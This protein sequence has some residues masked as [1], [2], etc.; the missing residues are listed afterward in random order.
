MKWVYFWNEAGREAVLPG[1]SPP[2]L[3]NATAADGADAAHAAPAAPARP[4]VSEAH[5][6]EPAV[7]P[8]ASA[9]E[10]VAAPAAPGALLPGPLSPGARQDDAEAHAAEP[11]AVVAALGASR[12]QE[13]AATELLGIPCKAPP[14]RL[15]SMELQ[16][17][18]IKAPPPYPPRT[19]IKASGSLPPGGLQLALLEPV[20]ALAA[21]G[22]LQ[23]WLIKAPPPRLID[24]HL[25]LLSLVEPAAAPAA[26]GAFQPGPLSPFQR[27][28]DSSRSL[29]R[30]GPVSWNEANWRRMVNEFFLREINANR[31][32]WFNL[33]RVSAF[34]R[35]F[36]HR[37]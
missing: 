32:M 1:A 22:A 29:V 26:P 15:W 31:C 25:V 4:D 12:E 21:P 34:A 10:P 28:D 11:V 9:A 17:V 30:P 24:C 18:P 33:R 23:P 20:A 8:V 3:S 2:G 19:P 27:E 37:P 14:R 13:T 16:D 5:A 36:W 6:D 35:S 7:A